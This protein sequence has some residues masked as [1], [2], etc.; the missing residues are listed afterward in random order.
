MTARPRNLLWVAVLAT[1]GL[2]CSGLQAGALQ[3]PTPEFP[4]KDTPEASIFRGS[5]VFQN[6]CLKCHGPLADG[7]GRAA[8]L[9]TPRPANLV[10]SD[11]NDMYKE[12][13]IRRGGGGMARSPFMPP[14]NDELTN[15]QIRDVVTYLHSI[16]EHPPE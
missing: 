8:K 7:N 11:K 10:K 9:Y 3:P 14:W 12:L 5:A 6:Y 15:E 1:A 16:A 13:I 4:D 2:A